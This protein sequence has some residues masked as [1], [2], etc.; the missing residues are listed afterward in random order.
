MHGNAKNTGTGHEFPYLGSLANES[1]RNSVPPFLFLTSG[2][3]DIT[4]R[5]S[6]GHSKDRFRD[7]GLANLTSY[8]S[9]P[10][11][12]AV[13]FSFSIR[14]ILFCFYQGSSVFFAIR[15]QKKKIV[16]S[17]GAK[18]SNE[19]RGLS[20]EFRARFAPRESSRGSRAS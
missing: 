3:V 1:R 13:P 10:H 17:S 14:L 19:K 20:I 8:V 4:R 12:T 7:H 16:Y 9:S 11:V 5:A 6:V 15:L 2:S 18:R